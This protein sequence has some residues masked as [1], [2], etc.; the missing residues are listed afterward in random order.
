MLTNYYICLTEW[1]EQKHTLFAGE[2]LNPLV[3]EWEL[4]L[5]KQNLQT[6]NAYLVVLCVKDLQ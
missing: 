5:Q 3:P 4:R 1:S 6:S 2:H